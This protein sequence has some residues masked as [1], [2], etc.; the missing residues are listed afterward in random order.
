MQ[1]C[2]GVCGCRRDHHRARPENEM[3]E[4]EG[5]AAPAVVSGVAGP[6]S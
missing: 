4:Q 5:A 2:V 3:G 6:T 1:V